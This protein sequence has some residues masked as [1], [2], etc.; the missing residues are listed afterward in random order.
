[1]FRWLRGM[2]GDKVLAGANFNGDLAGIETEPLVLQAQ[3]LS[4]M[5]PELMRVYLQR[6]RDGLARQ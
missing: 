6:L 3:L 2:A 5:K 1:M 4:A